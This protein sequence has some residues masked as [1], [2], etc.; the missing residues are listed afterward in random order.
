MEDDSKRAMQALA[1][2][3]RDPAAAITRR[4]MAAGAWN[5]AVADA[6]ARRLRVGAVVSS[7]CG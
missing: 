6:F 2:V 5:S 7:D 1:R 3:V 4:A